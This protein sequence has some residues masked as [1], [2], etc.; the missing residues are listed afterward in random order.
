MRYLVI[1]NLFGALFASACTPKNDD[2][3]GSGY[4]WEGTGC[5]EEDTGTSDG[6]ADADTDTDADTD[7]DAGGSADGGPGTDFN[8]EPEQWI[9][10]SCSCEGAGCNKA[11]FDIPIPSGGN[12]I[13]CDD[14]PAQW[15]GAMKACMRSYRG[16]IPPKTYFANGYCVMLATTCEGHPTICGDAEF[17]NYED[18]TVCPSG[19][20]MINTIQDVDL[21][22][23]Q[24]TINT[25]TCILGCE[26]DGDCRLDE[27][28]PVWNNQKTEYEC[29]DKNDA[30]FC[31]DPRNLEGEYSAES[32]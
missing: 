8:Y 13:D 21:G 9:G 29:V 28:D 5:W 6:D 31:F 22:G 17:G 11:G 16:I 3:C 15:Q 14:V 30:S 20:V 32:F 12:I 7:I 1:V 24:A 10:S 25:K 19:T 2:R 26:D 18:M 23:L 27:N 4:Y